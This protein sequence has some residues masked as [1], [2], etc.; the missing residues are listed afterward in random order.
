MNGLFGRQSLL[1]RLFPNNP[2]SRRYLKIRGL[3]DTATASVQVEHVSAA[4]ML[5]WR[6]IYDQVGPWD[7]GFHSYWVDADWCMRIKKAGGE[8][9]YLPTAR[10]IHYEQN[11]R[12]VKK[13]PLR[14]IKFHTGALRF[15]TKHYTA[16][17]YDPRSLAAAA[18]L[19][20][21]TLLLLTT[22]HFKPQPRTG[23][24]PLAMQK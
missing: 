8:I 17:I 13:S 9:Y 12:Q 16:G 6:R 18:L 15:Y 3:K 11:Q 2:F 24:D 21:R 4:C 5:F 10:I 19:A 20:V 14:I 22:N 23:K 1:T 7:E